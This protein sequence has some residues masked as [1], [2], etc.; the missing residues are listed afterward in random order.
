MLCTYCKRGCIACVA[1]GHN[2]TVQASAVVNAMRV[3][4]P[5]EGAR[6]IA[7]LGRTLTDCR[8]SFCMRLV[9]ERVVAAVVESGLSCNAHDHARRL[10]T[11][12]LSTC[13]KHAAEVRATLK[14][15]Q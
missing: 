5:R 13:A 4:A 9:L 8:R 11:P 2:R 3:A 7:V 14:S 1:Q 12:P 15:G 6:S 10:H